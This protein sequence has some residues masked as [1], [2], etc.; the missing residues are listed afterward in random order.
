MAQPI[1]EAAKKRWETEVAKAGAAGTGGT[2]GADPN[3][4]VSPV[5]A[6]YQ[7]TSLG[8]PGSAN[9]GGGQMPT[10]KFDATQQVPNP[11]VPT[12]GLTPPKLSSAGVNSNKQI[13]TEDVQVG[14]PATR[15]GFYKGKQYI[16]DANGK[17]TGELKD[18]WVAMDT[19]GAYKNAIE[20]YNNGVKAYNEGLT[21]HYPMPNIGDATA[22]LPPAETV[23][24]VGQTGKGLISPVEKKPE[25]IPPTDWTKFIPTWLQPSPDDIGGQIKKS[26]CKDIVN[27]AA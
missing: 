3:A 1:D 18:V 13:F 7:R 16:L 27:W 12:F 6:P 22:S 4:P 5:A 9:M 15:P 23:A 8:N 11:N 25:F 10:P 19:A 2:F 20:N 17:N 24:G 14:D 26:I 21:D